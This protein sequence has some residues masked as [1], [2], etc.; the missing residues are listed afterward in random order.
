[1]MAP[2][3][4]G[5]RFVQ[6]CAVAAL[7]ALAVAGCGEKEEPSAT[8]LDAS[9]AE[10]KLE[11]ELPIAGAWKGELHQKGLKPFT[12]TARIA[13]A[14]GPNRVHYSGID[15][16]G[17]WTYEGQVGDEYSFHEAIDRGKGGK[18]KGAGTVT[19]RRVAADRLDYEFRGGGIE[20]RG[21]LHQVD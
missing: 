17:R 16:S 12:V 13:G 1:M 15:C 3:L 14:E 9:S 11:T 20:S 8:E 4:T 10:E 7:L 2:A 18:C 5:R 21:V 6:I 19:L